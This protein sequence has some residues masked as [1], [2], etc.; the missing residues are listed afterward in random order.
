[1]ALV[2]LRLKEA[3]ILV[4]RQIALSQNLKLMGIFVAFKDAFLANIR[5]FLDIILVQIVLIR[6]IVMISFGIGH[7]H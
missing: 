4:L 1:M 5:F 2:S 7:D 3:I 6:S